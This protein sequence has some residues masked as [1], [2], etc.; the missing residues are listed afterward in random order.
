MFKRLLQ[1]ECPTAGIH[2]GG[3]LGVNLEGCLVPVHHLR[4]AFAVRH[5]TQSEYQVRNNL[6]GDSSLTHTCLIV[7]S[8]PIRE[9]RD[10]AGIV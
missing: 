7:R 6:R 4:R 1:K 8:W 2:Q 5:P 9:H 3:L 10:G